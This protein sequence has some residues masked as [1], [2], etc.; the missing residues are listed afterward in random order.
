MISFGRVL[1]GL[2]FGVRRE[3]VLGFIGEM[4]KM[5]LLSKGMDFLI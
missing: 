3:E 2:G 1:V 4:D 5:S